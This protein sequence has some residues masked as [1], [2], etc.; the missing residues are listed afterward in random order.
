[1]DISQVRF[2]G[3]LCR[4]QHC[5]LLCREEDAVNAARKLQQIPPGVPPLKH[6]HAPP[7]LPLLSIWML[8]DHFPQLVSGSFA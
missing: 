4:M 6:K 1:M 3:S 2:E 8:Y 5:D 7:L